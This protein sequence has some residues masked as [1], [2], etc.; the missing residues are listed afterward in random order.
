MR[1]FLS[2]YIAPFL[3]KYF[4]K[5]KR[6]EI[7]K[8]MRKLQWNSLEDNLKLQKEKLFKILDYSI[9]N[10]PYYKRIAEENNIKIAPETIFEDIKKFPVL[11]KEIIREN[12]N[13]LVNKKIKANF[14]TSGGSTGE[15]AIFMQDN[16]MHDHKAATK[17]LFN[18]WAGR[19]EGDTLIKLWGSERDILK[20]GM[21]FNGFLLRNFS[22]VFILNTY[23]MSEKNMIKYIDIINKKKP[24][25]ILAYA[26]S[27]FEISDFILK[28]KIKVYSPKLIMTSAGM[29]FPHFKKTIEEAFK[30]PVFNRYGSREVGDIACTCEKQAGLH[31]NLFTQYVE[32]L[33]SNLK[34]VDGET[35]GDIYITNLSNYVMPLIR[36]QIGD[37]GSFL[38]DKCSCGR[39]FPML[40]NIS[41]R[42]GCMLKTK[43]GSVDSTA[44]TTSFYFFESIKKYQVIQ[45]GDDFIV[46]VVIGSE[47][48]WE[49]DKKELREKLS[50]IFGEDV[51]LTFE[52]V[53]EIPCTK[54]GKYLYF[55]NENDFYK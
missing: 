14:N 2:K 40:K 43:S 38:M 48:K 11:T 6:Y 7:F 45:K 20:G 31:V 55:I 50:K 1:Y 18:E 44:L 12:F 24:V 34:N 5:S 39:G 52:T 19:K 13:S 9:N 23:K 32:I 41:G 4:K 17:M 10:I 22:N 53:D 42:I 27:A 47:K 29:L 54:S 15:Q 30:C 46:R 51:R 37:R 28:N 36:Y 49:T 25:M 16:N 21:G 26:T 35:S 33:D 3:W 8:E